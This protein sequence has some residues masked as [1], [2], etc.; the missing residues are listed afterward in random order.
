MES[1]IR[2]GIDFG[3]TYCCVG[4]WTDGGVVIIPNGIGERTTPS[5]VI[6]DSPN[7][8]YVGEETLYHLSKK[9]SVKIYEIKRLIGKTYD[10]IQELLDYFPFTIIKDDYNNPK[11]KMT[12]DNGQS[13]EHYPEEIAALI[14]KKLIKNAE[15][16]LQNKKVNEIII[17]VP[18]DFTNTQRNKIK[19]AAE[20]IG[21]IKVLQL[22][23]EPSASVLSYGFPKEL[24]KNYFNFFNAFN[25]NYTL[26]NYNPQK[27]LHPMEENQDDNL[28]NPNPF[29]YSLKTSFLIQED[30]KNVLVFD[31]GGGTYDVS[32]IEVTDSIFETRATRG[33]QY[34]GGGDLDNKLM[35]YCLEYFSNIIKVPKEEIQKNYKSI[36]R[37][38]IACEKTKKILSI[39]EEDKIYVDNFYKD[40]TLDCS[41]SRAK[42]ED[43]CQDCFDKLIKP[44]DEVLQA[45]KKNAEDI[46]EIILVGGSSKIPKVK[47]ILKN[48]FPQG[49]INDSISPDEAV[50]YGAT[51]YCESLRRNTGEFW[52]DFKYL[53]ATQHSYGVELEDGT[54]GVIIPAGD[55]YPTS[56]S[57]FFFNAYDDQYTFEIK[58]YEG[59]NEY[60][61]ENELLETF[62][63]ENIPKKKKHELCLTITF[64]IDNN[65]ILNVTATVEEN[66]STKSIKINKKAKNLNEISTLQL[67]RISLIGNDLNKMEKKFKLEIMDYTKNFK[68][69]NDDQSKYE[70]IK[71][72]NK[73]L[74][75]YLQ[76]LEENYQDYESEK[77]LFLV[78]KL[79][80]SYSYFFKTQ[81]FSMVE[82]NE[83]NQINKK[84]ESY[85]EKISKKCPYR[86]KYLL[87]NFKDIKI[88]KSKIYYTSS[89]YSMRILKSRGDEYY[90]K[91]QNNSNQIAKNI[92]EE[93]LIIGKICFNND[94]IL[95]II[96]LEVRR[97][98][99]EIKDECEDKIKLISADSISEIENTKMTGNLFS[100]NNGLDDD[101]LSL[102]TFN[103]YQS[104]SKINAI[105]DLDFNKEALL[106]KAICLANIVKI[107]SI[108]IISASSL[109]HLFEL[110]EESI[111][112]ANKLGEIC[113]NKN[114]YNEIHDLK[115][116]IKE[117]MDVLP[118]PIYCGGGE[119]LENIRSQLENNFNN[120]GN[121]EFLRFLLTNY[122]YDGCQ[123]SDDM[124]EEFKNNKRTFLKKLL[125]KY[126]R[127]G[128][129]QNAIVV[130]KNKIIELYIN[131]MINRLS[132]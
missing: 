29:N 9:D 5:V 99:E 33:N 17:T 38:K 70:I 4:V 130:E 52:E 117:K 122:P 22:I 62:V 125:I 31:F 114:W 76:F 21:G 37:L 105:E 98:Y 3:T 42:F 49:K 48:K 41:I 100:N 111:K 10:Q 13:I 20:S 96:D 123:F 104:L 75:D 120:Y 35:E 32:L 124:I 118:P 66:G 25:Q 72:Y 93:C 95:S 45:S 73:S 63:L 60:A 112:I 121:E 87:E 30:D 97:D 115:E 116:K 80:K 132:Q 68:M 71:N 36:Q 53:D 54:M 74:N 85:I 47:E 39:K 57:K 56:K 65:Q 69:M 67:G 58:V 77:Y 1:K 7:E 23:N 64:S 127:T 101:N 90:K 102:L 128:N 14:I 50:A 91:K 61:N 84:V 55:K 8:V 109:Q 19:S 108:K 129:T 2:L 92:Y 16:F 46:K 110:A 24:L 131:N 26:V 18:S 103:F 83:K 15:S 107:E 81:L 11:I 44:I 43:L 88:D 113:T 28:I 40:E 6:F 12:F 119:D 78:D 34:L 79:F 51:F 126:K 59:E 27:I 82:Y 106:S 89:T 86:I 94:K